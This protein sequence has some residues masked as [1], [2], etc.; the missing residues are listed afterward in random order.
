MP[1]AEYRYAVS[2]EMER[3]YGI[4][5]ADASGDDDLLEKCRASIDPSD[6]VQWWGQKYDLTPKE[7][8]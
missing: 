7:G 3:V 4:T 2:K 6:F 5:W 8:F 1:L